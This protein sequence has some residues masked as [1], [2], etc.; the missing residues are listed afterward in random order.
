MHKNTDFPQFRKLSNDK[1]FY[2]INS[3]RHFTEV[4]F[5]GTSKMIFQCEAKQYPEILKIQDMLN[6]EGA[7]EVLTDFADDLFDN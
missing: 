6:L 1:V 2:R 3:D 7:Y 4:Q 5:I